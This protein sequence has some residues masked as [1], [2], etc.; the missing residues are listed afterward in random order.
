[1]ELPTLRLKRQEERRLQGGHLWIYSNE[2]NIRETPLKLFQAGEQ[3]RV[4]SH[5]GKFLGI[6]YVNPQSLICGRLV[7]RDDHR[8]DRSLLVHRL[9]QALQ[10]RRRLFDQPFYR[11]V[12]GESDLLP[13]LVVDRFGGHL[14]VQLNSAGMAAVKG[15][16][17]DALQEVVDPD[18]ILLRNDSS[19]RTL[20]GL[21]REIEVALGKVPPEVELIENGVRMLAPLHD[22]QK[23]GWFYD[24]RPNRA[25]LRQFARGGRVLDVFSYVGSFGVQ[26]AAFGAREVIAVDASRPALEM[27]EKNAALNGVDKIFNCIQGD[28]FAV[29]KGLKA[30]GER[31]DVIVV[32][33]PAFIKRKKDHKE[34]LQ[35][36]HRINEQAMQLLVPD[37]ILVSA[38]CSMHLQREELV[39]VLRNAGR[40]QGRHVQIL[41]EG[42]QGPD[43]PVHPAIAETRYLKAFLARVSQG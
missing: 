15:E 36:Y 20:E 5:A 31:F 12:Y 22:G 24:Q 28:A 19:I 30:E 42:M 40:R 3:V 13:G 41:L 14:A 11:L 39:D 21:D 43:H 27:A 8:L 34:G 38:S 6:A 33:P 1:M 35:A 37:G 4:E 16:I 29:L 23:T 7:S 17:I 9:Q 25:W 18:S 32:D 10:L 2:V 26:A